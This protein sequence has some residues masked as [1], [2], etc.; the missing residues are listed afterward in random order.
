MTREAFNTISLGQLTHDEA[1]AAGDAAIEG[2]P[3]KLDEL[4][5][6]LDNFEVWFRIV[7]RL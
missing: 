5:S 4:L 1:I 3:A 6:Y 2:D 7:E